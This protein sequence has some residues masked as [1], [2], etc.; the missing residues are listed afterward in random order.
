MNT[1][2]SPPHAGPMSHVARAFLSAGPVAAIAT[3]GSIVTRP[4]IPTWY[5]GLA[6]PAGTPPNWLFAPAWGLLYALMAVSLWRILSHPVGRPGR[7]GALLAFTTQLL[8]NGLWSWSFFGARNAALGAINILVLDIA[9][10]V[11]ILLFA[12]LDRLAA[13]LLAPYAAWVAYATYLNIGV[14]ALNR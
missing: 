6:K 13:W 3:A 8:L 9:I 4:A 1:P 7:R 2:E 12:R 14:W 5:E 10:A 11:T